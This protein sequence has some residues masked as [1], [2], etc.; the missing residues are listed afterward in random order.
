MYEGMNGTAK[1]PRTPREDGLAPRRGDAE[2]RKKRDERL[3]AM[4]KNPDADERRM[5]IRVVARRGW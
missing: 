2:V 1:T 3:L 4:E 5:A